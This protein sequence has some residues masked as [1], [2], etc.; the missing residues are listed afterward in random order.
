MKLVFRY[1]CRMLL[2]FIVFLYI[3]NEFWVNDLLFNV[4]KDVFIGDNFDLRL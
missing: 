3:D 4:F 1:S 2:R